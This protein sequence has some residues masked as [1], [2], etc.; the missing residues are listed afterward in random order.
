MGRVV[1]GEG[2]LACD[3][4]RTQAVRILRRLLQSY[5]PWQE[6]FRVGERVRS[7]SVIV[8][9]MI[10]QRR[11]RRSRPP[12]RVGVQVMLKVLPHVLDFGV[13]VR[14][15]V[16]PSVLG[17]LSHENT[18]IAA[19]ALAVLRDLTDPDALED[20]TQ[21]GVVSPDCLT[22][23]HG[24]RFAGSCLLFCGEAVASA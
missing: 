10:F 2:V 1:D 5:C 14:L 17:L 24:R 13:Q 20:S 12:A 6:R 16:L 11:G 19:A 3:D 21:N 7:R 9:R 4:K 18:D 15:K 8:V 22:P 23:D